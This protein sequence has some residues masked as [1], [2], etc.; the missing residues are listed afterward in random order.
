MILVIGGIKGGSGKSTLAT[1]LTVLRAKD[2]K[3]VLLVDAD[4]QK[5]SST[6]A[7]QRVGGRFDTNWT[8]ITLTGDYIYSQLQKLTNDYDDIIIDTGGRDTVSLRSALTVADKF[9]VPFKPRSYDIWTLGQ[10]KKLINEI[11]VI[12][13]DL[14]TYI[15]INQGDARGSD[16]DES[17]EI[18]KECQDI[19]CLN[20]VITNRKTFGNAA[21]DGLSIIEV[22]NRDPKACQELYNLYNSI[23]I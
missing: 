3:K 17:L 9:L 15:V 20:D 18:L 1:N 2:N 6:W 8:T 14:K 23:Y 16:N 5:T 7:D 22:S 19:T 21:S 11:K 13:R 12:N 10:V 4:D